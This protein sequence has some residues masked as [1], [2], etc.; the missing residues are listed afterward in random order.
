MARP[1]GMK[2][3]FAPTLAVCDLRP[4]GP[5]GAGGHSQP[6][7]GPPCPFIRVFQVGSFLGGL[8]K[9]LGTKRGPPPPKPSISNANINKSNRIRNYN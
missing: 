4:A 3:V 9:M 2:I 8:G 1:G 6:S 7:E 5:G